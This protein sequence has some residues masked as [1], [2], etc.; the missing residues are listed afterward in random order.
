MKHFTQKFTAAALGL[1]AL[2]GLACSNNGMTDLNEQETLNND[3][4]ATVTIVTEAFMTTSKMST[5]A[6]TMSVDSAKVLVEELSL[7]HV[8]DRDSLDFSLHPFVMTLDPSQP[9]QE[10]ALSEVPFGI[11]DEFELEIDDAE[12][13]LGIDDEDFFPSA[14]ASDGFSIIVYG[15]YDGSPFV[16]RTDK[17]FKV[18]MDFEPELIVDENSSNNLEIRLMVN[19]N[20][21]FLAANGQQID[22]NTPQAQ[23]QI[24]EAIRR[25]FR[26]ISNNR[27]GDNDANNGEGNSDQ[28]NDDNDN[29]NWDNYSSSRE[30]YKYFENTGLIPGAYGEVEYEVYRNGKRKFEVEVEDLPVGEYEIVVGGNVVGTIPVRFDD[31]DNDETEGE[32]LYTNPQ[33]R[34]T[35]VLD[36][37]PTNELI[38]IRQ[39]GQVY[40]QTLLDRSNVGDGRDD[41][42]D[43][44]DWDDDDYDDE[45]YNEYDD[46]DY[47]DNDDSSREMKR[48]FT[49]TGI[50]SGADGYVEYEVYRNGNRE[51]EVDIDDLAV[52]SYEIVVDGEVVGSIAVRSYYDGTEGETYF[53]NPQRSNTQLLDFDPIG[54]LIQVRQDGQVYLE[55]TFE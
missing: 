47:D 1:A 6:Y 8:N 7:E 25:S 34:G 11:Y 53:T 33:R 52:G 21:W 46:D 30:I 43:Y 54:K 19:L 18:E 40:L 44:D 38:E 2:T 28:D 24:E 39:D 9:S 45:D 5:L 48:R 15:R 4:K 55:V 10:V 31:D 27:D 17:K 32:V 13:W 41:D 22:P 42:D 26:V 51:L 37:D 35:R 36:F 12:R 16:F 20:D 49:N 14:A 50:I 29:S 3:Q 23:V